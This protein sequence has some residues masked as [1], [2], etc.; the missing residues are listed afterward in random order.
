MID[1]PYREVEACA[2]IQATGP[3]VVAV[4]NGSIDVGGF[5]IEDL[6][7][8]TDNSAQDGWDLEPHVGDVY[9]VLRH[10]FVHYLLWRNGF[11]DDANAGHRSP[12]FVA[13]SG[14]PGILG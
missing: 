7:V 4:P 5:Q 6:V 10:E 13:C 8:V 11:P 14:L 2:G 12:L 1:E 9:S 3:L